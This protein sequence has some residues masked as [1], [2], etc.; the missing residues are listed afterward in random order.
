MGYSN[1]DTAQEQRTIRVV[2]LA[3]LCVILGFIWL[4]SKTSDCN[5][6]PASLANRCHDTFHV[7]TEQST[8]YDC[9]PGSKAEIVTAPPAPKPG[10]VCH[11]ITNE[12]PPPPPAPSK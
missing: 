3:L 11:C 1:D 6:P 4:G 2:V 8:S 7:V 9:P 5:P 10:V 12:E